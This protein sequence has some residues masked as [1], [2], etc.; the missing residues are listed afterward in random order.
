MTTQTT[1]IYTTTQTPNG[2]G[3]GD[4][5]EEMPYACCGLSEWGQPVESVIS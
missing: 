5:D 3:C 2:R 1:E 4:R